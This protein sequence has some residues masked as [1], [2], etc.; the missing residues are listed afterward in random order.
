VVDYEHVDGGFGRRQLQAK[1]LLEGL[2]DTGGVV[3]RA[4]RWVADGTV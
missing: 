1:L 2:L 3:V 4:G